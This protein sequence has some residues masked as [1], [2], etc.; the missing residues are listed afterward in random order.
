MN[1]GWIYREKVDDSGVGQTLLNYY[2]QRYP[3][4]NLTEWHTRILNGQIL[5]EEQ[6]ASP[7]QILTKNQRLT[8]RRSPWIEPDVPLYFEVL[9]EDADLWIIAKPSGLPVLPGGGFLEH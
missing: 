4:S 5:V 9:Y 3:H 6:P 8:Y 7:D 2:C 1:Q